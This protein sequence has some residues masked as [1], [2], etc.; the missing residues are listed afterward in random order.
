VEFKY[1]E[2]V[3]V[4]EKLPTLDFPIT[5]KTLV[6]GVCGTRDLM[7]YHHDPA[8][9][10]SVGN[11]DMFVNTMFEQ[12]LFGR[13]VID[14]CGPESDFRETGLQML[15]QLCPG[16]VAKIEGQVT[17]KLEE[18]G[19]KRVKLQLSASNEI[20]M[21]ASG[22]ATIAMPSRESGPVQPVTSM[23]RPTMEPH[24]EIPDFAKAWLGVES[25]KSPG[26]YPVSE[27]QVMYWC[28]MVEDSNP[29]YG[30]TE[31]ARKSRHKG[32]IAPPMGLITW[33]MARAG[34]TGV[35]FDAPDVNCPER[36]PWPPKDESAKRSPMPAPPGTTE[37]IAQ[38][39]VQTYGVPVRPGDHISSTNEVLNC[40][41][42]K[43]T[44]LGPG[45]FQTNL[46]TFYNQKGDIVG[47]NLFTLLRYGGEQGQS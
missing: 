24:P 6:L 17:E 32:M 30:D 4:G 3:E 39:S 10:K 23:K 16:D 31:Y 37:T 7:P 1:W 36:K 43:Q 27:V 5:I 21:A 20:G 26:G 13:F 2:D 41:P 33:T 25:E 34:H 18:D 9:S 44:K 15:N 45:Y 47:T 19:E 28:D 12:A 22:T 40:S 42:R 46:Q 35:D 8:Y 14:W 29:L 38:G 11:R